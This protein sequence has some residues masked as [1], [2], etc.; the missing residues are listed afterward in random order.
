MNNVLT[1]SFHN[2]TNLQDCQN[3]LVL[4]I[5]R[6]E[7]IPYHRNG[8]IST[9]HSHISTRLWDSSRILVGILLDFNKITKKAFS[10]IFSFPSCWTPIGLLPDSY[11]TPTGLQLNLNNVNAMLQTLDSYWIVFKSPVRSGYLVPR[12]SN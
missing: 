3:F 9:Y 1:P 10:H 12:G 11:W 2:S 5:H 8:I 6:G 4:Q 7:I